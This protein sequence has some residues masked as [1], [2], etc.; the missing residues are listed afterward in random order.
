ILNSPV[1]WADFENNLRKALGTEARLGANK[2]VF[3]IGD[4]NGYANLCGLI[5]CDWVGASEDE[6]LPKKVIIKIPS[7]LPMRKLNDSLPDDHKMF[8]FNEEQWAAM[9]AQLIEIHNIEVATYDFL[10]EFEGLTMPKQFYAKAFV[11][12]EREGGQI[13]L[14]YIAN[15]RT[16]NFHERHTVEQ[17]RK[18]ARALGKIQACSLKK[19]VTASELQKDFFKKGAEMWSLDFR[20]MFK[21]VSTVDN[22][23]NTKTLMEKIDVLVEKYY[24]SN[25]PTTIHQQMGFRPVLVNGDLHISNVLIDKDTGDLASLIDW[26]STHLGVGVED[27]HRIALTSLPTT[28]RRSSMPMLVET[29]YESLVENLDGAEPPYTL[30]K[31]LLLSDLIFPQCAVF[32]ASGFIPVLTVGSFCEIAPLFVGQVSQTLSIIGILEDVVELDSK[33]KNHMLIL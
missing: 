32:F 19:E 21:G 33:K 23:D 20:G 9:E 29:M 12:V 17:L 5:T 2:D 7:V 27:L 28:E 4:G 26:Q 11:D 14:E 30:E 8:N 1:T 3:N 24:G 10:K 15:S 13:C 31:L 22:S 25:L 18:I 16:M 6:Q